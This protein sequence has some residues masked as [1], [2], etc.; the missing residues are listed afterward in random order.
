MKRQVR[1]FLAV[2]AVCFS[3]F[4]IP[5]ETAA[6]NEPDSVIVAL[7]YLLLEK[8]DK[9]DTSLIHELLSDEASSD[10]TELINVQESEDVIEKLIREC[11]AKE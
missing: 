2:V 5:A 4:S 10:L 6:S 7:E 11:S 3:F 8:S 1:F 9:L